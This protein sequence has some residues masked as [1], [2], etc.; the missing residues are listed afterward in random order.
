MLNDGSSGRVLAQKAATWL[1]PQ[2][3]E[4]FKYQKRKEKKTK[5]A[6]VRHEVGYLMGIRKITCF[7][8]STA[9]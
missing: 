7:I 1:K 2:R 4:I 3:I 6:H 9:S 8:T 5:A